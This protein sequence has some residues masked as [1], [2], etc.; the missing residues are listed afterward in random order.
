MTLAESTCEDLLD[1]ISWVPL[2]RPFKAIGLVQMG[3]MKSL[4]VRCPR[5]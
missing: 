4:P 1:R 5:C 3:P 2:W